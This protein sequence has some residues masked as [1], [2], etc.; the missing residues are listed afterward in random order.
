[1]RQ[2]LLTFID[3]TFNLLSVAI[4]IRIAMSWIGTNKYSSLFRFFDDVTRPILDLAKRIT[5]QIGMLDFSPVVALLGLGVI[6]RILLAI[7][8][9]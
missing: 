2:V 5:P 7:L 4:F 3:I 9:A 6:H 1:M 8:L